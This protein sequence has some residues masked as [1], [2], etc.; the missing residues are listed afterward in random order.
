VVVGGQINVCF[1]QHVWLE[2]VLLNVCARKGT[3]GQKKKKLNYGH[4]TKLPTI[5]APP[6]LN[7]SNEYGWS[8]MPT[9]S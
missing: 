8:F 4:Q 7:G 6:K 1:T 2:M 3:K 5:D 9:T